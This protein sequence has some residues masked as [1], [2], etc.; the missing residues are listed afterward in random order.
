MGYRSNAGR[1]RFAIAIFIISSLRIPAA[2]QTTSTF[3]G[4][5]RTR[6]RTVFLNLTGDPKYAHRLW[7][8]LD[9]ELEDVGVT[10]ANTEVGADAVIDGTVA[11]EVKNT[12]FALGA[13]RLGS[14]AGGSTVDL[15][16][17]ASLSTDANAAVFDTS[18]AEVGKA[19][20]EKYPSATTVTIDPRSDLAKS[21]RFKD[22]LIR[23]LR[24]SGFKVAAS[25][26]SDITLHV[27]LVPLKVPIEEKV[28]HYEISALAR[29]GTLLNRATGDGVLSA[30]ALERAPEECP[31]RLD[32]M[33]WLSDTNALASAARMVAQQ[34]KKQ[35]TAILNP[36]AKR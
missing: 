20:R 21:E 1:M 23:S 3:R 36:P 7:T 11:T 34:L 24:D 5:G 33:D 4:S 30:T 32:N 16:F 17:C 29:D 15:S 12:T 31:D 8:Y 26:P 2:A 14:T 35:N 25:P 19:V 10:L 6:I 22:N 9:F 27:D 13:V 18:G 28:V